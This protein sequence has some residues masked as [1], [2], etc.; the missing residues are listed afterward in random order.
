MDSVP[1]CCT[2]RRGA[3]GEAE[4]CHHER[5]AEDPAEERGNRSEKSA[6]GIH[7]VSLVAMCATKGD[8]SD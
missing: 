5:E 7:L 6:W 3:E 1:G 8:H 4:R 2:R